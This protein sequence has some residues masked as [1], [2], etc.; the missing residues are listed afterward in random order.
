M[1]LKT[2]AFI[3]LV[4]LV[5]VSCLKTDNNN[6]CPYRLGTINIPQQEKDALATYIDTSNIDA[7]QDN[8]GFYYRI[9]SPGQGT[10]SMTLCSQ[11]QI[12]YKASLTND[13]IFDRQQ[14]VVF[15][16]GSLIEGWRRGI[17]KIKRGGRMMLYVPPTLGYGNRDVLDST[18]TKVIIPKN[19]IT[20]YD[21]TLTDYTAGN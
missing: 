14:N 17:P 12:S 3:L 19:S 13:T 16:L 4:S 8:S 5:A 10:D 6:S 11:I 18:G 20:K 2:L 1:M 9:I 15:V 7:V 21:I